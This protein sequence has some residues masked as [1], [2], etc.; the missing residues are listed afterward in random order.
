MLSKYIKTIDFY[1]LKWTGFC[2]N[3][4]FLSFKKAQG[5]SFLLK[6]QGFKTEK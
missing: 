5:L 6:S 3:I 4:R 2:P 1:G